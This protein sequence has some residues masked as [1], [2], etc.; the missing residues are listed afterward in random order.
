MYKVINNKTQH[1]DMNYHI[2]DMLEKL[3]DA[4]SKTENQ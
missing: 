1:S 2:S 3:T 4:S